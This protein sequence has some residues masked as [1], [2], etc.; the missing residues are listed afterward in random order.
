LIDLIVWDA[1][2]GAIVWTQQLSAD[3]LSWA[4]SGKY[5]A[6]TDSGLGGIVDAASG[7]SIATFQSPDGSDFG[8]LSWSPDSRY[9][10]TTSNGEIQIWVA[11]G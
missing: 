2:S 11:P 3:R 5:I 8:A 7:A 6:W 1:S 4:P 9:I 10:A